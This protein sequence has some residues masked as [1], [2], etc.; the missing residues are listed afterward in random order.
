M[1]NFLV[2]IFA[3]DDGPLPSDLMWIILE[4]ANMV[5]YTNRSSYFYLYACPNPTRFI[6]CFTEKEKRLTLIKQN[7][8]L[9]RHAGADRSWGSSPRVHGDFGQ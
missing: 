7:G 4:Y 3:P 6:S 5:R 2:Q 8:S 1:R 9:N